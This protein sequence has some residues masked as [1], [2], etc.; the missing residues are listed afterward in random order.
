MYSSWDWLWEFT[1][2]TNSQCGCHTLRTT[3]SHLIYQLW[4]LLMAGLRRILRLHLGSARNAAMTNEWCLLQVR[5][6]VAYIWQVFALLHWTAKD[7]K[8]MGKKAMSWLH[9]F[10]SSV[11][12]AQGEWRVNWGEIYITY[13]KWPSG[14]AGWTL[15]LEEVTILTMWLISLGSVQPSVDSSDTDGPAL[16]CIH[17]TRTPPA[18]QS[19]FTA[20]QSPST[21]PQSPSTALDP[22]I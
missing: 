11:S 10:L 1:F 14:V 5:E 2:L 19:L 8:M 17:G 15:P 16:G 21:A 20:P 4:S 13:S 9:Q 12:M 3:G 7:L 18:L 6:W 22:E